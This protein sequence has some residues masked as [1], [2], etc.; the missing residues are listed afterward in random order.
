MEEEM[1]VHW[2]K[3]PVEDFGDCYAVQAI[4]QMGDEGE[5]KKEY[6]CHLDEEPL[7]EI[8]NH[9]KVSIKPWKISD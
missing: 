4:Y 2:T 5:I 1:I 3:G 8:S 7:L 6:L 9:F